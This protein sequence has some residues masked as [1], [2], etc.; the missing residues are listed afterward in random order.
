MPTDERR[1][2][3]ADRETV[4]S[5]LPV[6]PEDEGTIIVG[7]TWHQDGR[8]RYTVPVFGDPY[9]VVDRVLDA[10][11][12][13]RWKPPPP[14]PDGIHWRTGTSVGCTV[15]NPYGDLSGM[16]RTP[17]AAAAVVATLNARADEGD[18]DAR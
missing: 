8:M 4:R 13:R 3:D 17:E 15:Y 18:T 2:T 6:D 16:M 12:A 7:Y 10:L 5:A 14:E 11:T 9:E 1:W